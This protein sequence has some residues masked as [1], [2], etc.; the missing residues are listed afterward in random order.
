MPADADAIVG[1][2]DAAVAAGADGVEVAAG[3]E[4]VEAT[5][6][7][8]YLEVAAGADDVEVTAG[9]E[10]VEVAAGAE[11]VEVTAGVEDAGAAAATDDAVVARTFDVAVA[12]RAA[13]PDDAAMAVV[14]DRG[15]WGAGSAAKAAPK[16]PGPAKQAKTE[17]VAT[18]R[19]RA[20]GDIRASMQL[21]RLIYI[22]PGRRQRV[23]LRPRSMR[24]D[25]GNGNAA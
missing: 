5:A 10:D 25:S 6:G 17:Q 7:A 8:E 23:V 12:D 3:A 1:D 4:D 18:C 14:A 21:N 2:D 9:A 20:R 19:R 11:D 24:N 22:M 13:E 15:N 16:S